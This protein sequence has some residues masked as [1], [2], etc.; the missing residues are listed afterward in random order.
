M[1]SSPIPPEHRLLL[2]E[3][4][5]G[6][7]PSPVPAGLLTLP[8]LRVAVKGGVPDPETGQLPESAWR[9][10]VV[11]QEGAGRLAVYDI[12]GDPRLG[13]PYGGDGDVL[14]AL[15]ALADAVDADGRPLVDPVTGT[16]VAPSL[17]GIARVLGLEMS[18]ERAERIKG[19]LERLAAVRIRVTRV[20]QLEAGAPG[21]EVV[22]LPS[23]NAYPVW[24]DRPGGGEGPPVSSTATTADGAGA[25]VA[26]RRAGRRAGRPVPA[27]LDATW[28]AESDT[29][30][31]LITYTWRTDYHRTPR[32]EDWIARLTINPA[33]LAQGE[34]GWVGWIDCPTHA[35]LTRP[36]AKRL[37]QLCAAAAARQAPLR[38][39]LGVLRQLCG[40]AGHS[41][42]VRA[43]H[44]RA[45]LLAAA[46]ELRLHDVLAG[47]EVV[48]TGRGRYVFHFEPG[49]R[50]RIAGWLRGVGRLDLAESRVQ[51]LLLA[52]FDVAPRVA[53]RLVAGS[54]GQVQ[55]ML[56]YV[57]Y[58]QA[59]GRPVK[60]PG[61][62]V[63]EGVESGWSYATDDDFQAWLRTRLAALGAPTLGAV[64]GAGRA[65]GA[66]LPDVA[67][68]ALPAGR[69]HR[70]GAAPGAT[71]GA[72][73]SV[74]PAD[75]SPVDEGREA[76]A[77]G[78]DA[79]P[80]VG[81]PERAWWAE[82]VTEVAAGLHA[83]PRAYLQAARPAL[84]SG[85]TLLVVVRSELERGRLTRE[86]DALTEA[87]VRLSAGAVVEVLLLTPA[88]WRARGD[89][90]AVGSE[91]AAD[92]VIVTRQAVT[93]VALPSEAADG[94]PTGDAARPIRRRRRS[95]GPVAESP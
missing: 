69:A 28:V 46:E 79:L 75:P 90:V 3:V 16:F 95:V 38:F 50:L 65:P 26:A 80:M 39:E 12:A 29:S 17:R 47:A 91:H 20:R 22:T 15:A 10:R 45:D 40:M 18:R 78:L 43:A 82:A 1:P 62:Y 73:A 59:R 51:R 70:P 56:A 88:Q 42:S 67:A 71:S 8:I 33:L 72:A 61:R 48:S 13:L 93:A 83:L 58:R 11:A 92:P 23:G 53:E 27:G 60:A 85:A 52:S 2:A 37:Y 86:L 84:R 24:L 35:R 49:L 55:Q 74:A 21:L 89:D 68:P 30:E 63:I 4:G 76:A 81:D 77:L 25:P 6:E 34:R 57:L 7:L 54:A 41:A 94:A 32:G 36:I 66:R 5:V 31:Y 87:V 14:L 9:A 44:V 64:G 19:A